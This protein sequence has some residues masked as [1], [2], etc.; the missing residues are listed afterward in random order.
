[1]FPTVLRSLGWLTTSLA[2]LA[3][4]LAASTFSTTPASAEAMPVAPA[5]R[6]VAV[7][8]T[9]NPR[10]EPGKV[11]WHA[12]IADAHAAAQKSGRPVLVFHMMGQLDRQFC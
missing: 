2:V 3:T 10:V 7:A 9:D 1:M 6:A 11:K 12:T 8:E 4:A 5:P